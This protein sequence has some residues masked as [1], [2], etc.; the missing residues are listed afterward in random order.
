MTDRRCLTSMEDVTALRG[1]SFPSAGEVYHS[2]VR[3][4]YLWDRPLEMSLNTIKKMM[5]A[6]MPL[7]INVAV[8]KLINSLPL[9]ERR[10]AA[11]HRF[12]QLSTIHRKYFVRLIRL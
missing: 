2:P 12:A 10:W 3:E 7:T 6:V 5:M 4:K 8:L 9:L 1:S 11:R